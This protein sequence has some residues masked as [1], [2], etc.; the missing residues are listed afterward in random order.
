VSAPIVLRQVSFYPPI[1][2]GKYHAVS[3]LDGDE[4]A[5]CRAMILDR[6]IPPIM[7]TP[8]SERVPAMICRRCL[9]IV[10]GEE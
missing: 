4:I 9:K 10:E 2:G 1:G 8:L 7:L 5:T 6:E 3:R